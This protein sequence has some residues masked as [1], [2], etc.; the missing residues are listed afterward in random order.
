MQSQ[1]QQEN[2]ENSSPIHIPP[3]I[4]EHI[5]EQTTTTVEESTT[6]KQTTSWTTYTAVPHWLLHLA[7]SHDNQRPSGFRQPQL[8]IDVK[9]GH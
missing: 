9:G 6:V 4:P 7:G 3:T 1:E 5:T 8:P 2:K